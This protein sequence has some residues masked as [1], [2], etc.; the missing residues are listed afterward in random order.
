MG[1]ARDR[2]KARAT[3]TEFFSDVEPIRYEGPDAQDDLAYRFY[4]PARIVLGKRM[5]EQ[6]RI[7]VCYWHSFN[8]PGSDVFG[9]G[10]FDRPWLDG[11][12]AP[13]GCRPHEDG[14][15][16]RVLC[17]TRHAVLVFPRP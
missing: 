6:L 8:W 13:H 7:A 4:D 5:D 15:G 2:T 17:E 10:T 12:M 16:V 9:A 3:M 14:R 11:S 1:A